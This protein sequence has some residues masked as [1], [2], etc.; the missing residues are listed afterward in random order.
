[1]NRVWT[2]MLGA[3]LVA[4]CGSSDGAPA[5][6][7]D[8]GVAHDGGRIAAG[9]SYSTDHACWACAG[10][11][12]GSDYGVGCRG[13]DDCAQFCGPLPS[14][15]QACAYAGA[16]YSDPLCNGWPG[17][18]RGTLAGCT[19]G[20]NTDVPGDVA[21]SCSF[22]PPGGGKKAVT[23]AQPPSTGGVDAAC[24]W[25]SD[26][27]LPAGYTAVSAADCS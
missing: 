11:A 6:V 12:H 5:A 18:E 13:Q 1:M 19:S 27:C 17:P 9:C 23:P 21:Y 26:T 20:P 4:S 24:V 7:V 15:W 8:R 2:I 25:F 14:G 3:T 10:G 22:C 16:G